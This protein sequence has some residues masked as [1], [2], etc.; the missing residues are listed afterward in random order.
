MLLEG[1]EFAVDPQDWKFGGLG[2]RADIR[3]GV[4]FTNA[5]PQVHITVGSLD[6]QDAVD[7]TN[8][9]HRV[10]YSRY[11]TRL[12]FARGAFLLI[13]HRPIYTPEIFFKDLFRKFLCRLSAF[14]PSSSA[15]S[16]LPPLL[17]LLLPL[18]FLLPPHWTE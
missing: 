8:K 1:A 3:C 4:L 5:A 6:Q 9:F 12:I 13:M 14:S 10:P 7:V 16:P 2:Q 18:S 17:P 15:P 11:V